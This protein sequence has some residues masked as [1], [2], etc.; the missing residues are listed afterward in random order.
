MPNPSE[1]TPNLSTLD[2]MPHIAQANEDAKKAIR[3]RIEN[4]K[5]VVEQEKDEANPKLKEEYTFQFDWTDGRGKRWAGEF[6]NKVLTMRDR[7]TIG[8]WQAQWQLGLSHQSFDPEISGMNYLLAHMAV[9]LK[10]GK[11]ADWAKDL[12]SLTNTDLV[13]AL[14]EEVASHEATFHGR[15]RGQASS[16]KDR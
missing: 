9:S 14:Y 10:P 12:Q 5:E 15:D 16:E 8:A 4:Q 3:N 1:E 11:G 6:T 7:Q 13:Q 2:Q